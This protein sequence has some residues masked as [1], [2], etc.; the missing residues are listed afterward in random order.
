MVNS[1]SFHLGY[2]AVSRLMSSI[3]VNLGIPTQGGATS[4]DKYRSNSVEGWVQQKGGRWRSFPY[5]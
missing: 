3:S 4:F 2:G 1:I 5:M